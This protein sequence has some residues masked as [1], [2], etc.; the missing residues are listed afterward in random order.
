VRLPLSGG[1]HRLGQ[2]GGS[3]MAAVEHQRCGLQMPLAVWRSGMD[4]NEAAARVMDV[5][6]RLDNVNALPT[7][8]QHK[9]QEAA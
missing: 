3:G 8:P 2:P 1:D 4:K 7:S 6:L 5:P 9:Q